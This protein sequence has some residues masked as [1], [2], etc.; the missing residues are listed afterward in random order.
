MFRTLSQIMLDLHGTMEHAEDVDVT[1]GFDQAG[2]AVVAEQENA[3]V[4]LGMHVVPI[5]HFGKLFEDISV[6][7]DRENRSSRG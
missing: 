5:A 2:N 1:I 3:N 7:V 4:P 6:F